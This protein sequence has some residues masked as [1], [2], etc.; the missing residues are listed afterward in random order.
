MTTAHRATYVSARGL[1]VGQEGSYSTGGVNSAAFSAKDLPSQLSLKRR[2]QD[3]DKQLSKQELKRQLEARE[4]NAKEQ[5]AAGESASFTT[6]TSSS[7]SSS[8]SLLLQ[9]DEKIAAAAALSDKYNIDDDDNILKMYDDDDDDDDED[10]DDEDQNKSDSEEDNSDDND[11]SSDDDDDELELLRELQ[12]IKAER[13]AE[14][15]RKK[16]AATS[17]SDISADVALGNPLLSGSSTGA[18]KRRWDDDV[19]FRNQAPGDPTKV[20]KRFINDTIRN[21]FHK[22]FLKKYIN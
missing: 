15:K 6:A 4:N 11:S 14:A 19:V 2:D 18:I 10:E 7:S 8:S 21:T 1:G 5:R 9:K 20:Q 16:E 3:Q 13:E 22:K 12:K 17:V